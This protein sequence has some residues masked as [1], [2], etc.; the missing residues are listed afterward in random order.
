MPYFKIRKHG[1][2]LQELLA[3]FISILRMCLIM[4]ESITLQSHTCAHLPDSGQY[5]E[6]LDNDLQYPISVFICKSY[7]QNNNCLSLFKSTLCNKRGN[8]GILIDPRAIFQHLFV[9][10]HSA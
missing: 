7:G 10:I 4:L 3:I 8:L 2:V 6:S 9:R 1:L 5:S